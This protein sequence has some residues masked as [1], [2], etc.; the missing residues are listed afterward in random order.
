MK[1]KKK[2]KKDDKVDID[3]DAIIEQLELTKKFHSPIQKKEPSMK[4]KKSKGLSKD[5]FKN[6]DKEIAKSVKAYLETNDDVVREIAEKHL[7]D[8]AMTILKEESEGFDVDDIV[9]ESEIKDKIRDVIDNF[10]FSYAL[11]NE[12][13]DAAEEAIGEV[14][15]NYDF[16]SAVEEELEGDGSVGRHLKDAIDE[17]IEKA[18]GDESVEERIEKLVDERLDAK[19]DAYMES[20]KI[21]ELKQLIESYRVM[22]SVMNGE[23]AEAKSSSSNKKS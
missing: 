1:T 9:D 7:R 14:V 10:D 17:A 4:S 11:N 3:V 20:L 8:N 6:L 16:D 5:Q 23:K 21:P 22:A 19:F 2:P 18:L 12:I 13:E 15:K